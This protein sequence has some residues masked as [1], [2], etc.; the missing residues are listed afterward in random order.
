MKKAQNARGYM[1]R[2]ESMV[3]KWEEFES[4]M[5]VKEFEEQLE[6]LLDKLTDAL[7]KSQDEEVHENLAWL[8]RYMG[9]RQ[10]LQE[11]AGEERMSEIREFVSG[12][13]TSRLVPTRLTPSSYVL[14]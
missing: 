5:P 1:K 14:G 3:A 11:K 2:E 12:Y 10:R 4:R 9:E 8:K 7:S 13:P 6:S